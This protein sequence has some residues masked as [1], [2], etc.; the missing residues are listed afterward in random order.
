[1][2]EHLDDPEAALGTLARMARPW[3]L[4]SVPREPAWRAMNMARLKYLG[5]LGNTPGHLG[6]WSKRGFIRFLEREVEVVEVATPL[7]WTM[8]LCRSE[9]LPVNA[10]RRLVASLRRRPGVAAI[11]ALGIAWGLTMHAMGWAQ[12]AFFAQ[13]RALADGGAEIDRWHWESGDKAWID[14]HFYSVKAPGVPALSAPLYL[15]ID[16]EPGRDLTAA[17]VD[18]QRTTEHRRWWP[19][20]TPPYASQG[21]VRERAFDVADG[22]EQNAPRVWALTL[23]ISVIPAVF[24][25][26]GV[27]W[28]GDRLEPGYGTAAAVTLGV[29]TIV[30]SFAAEY[31][32]HVISAT[33][34]FSAFLLLMREREG[35]PSLRTVAAAGLLAG[36]AVSFEYQTGLVGAV[37]FFYALA[38]SGARLPRA[39]SYVAGAVAGAIPVF[40]YNWF[41]LGTPFEFAY[42]SAVSVIGTTGHAELGLNSDGFFGITVPSPDKAI[43]LFFSQRGLL[44]L[45]PILVMAVVGTVLMRRRHRAEANVILAVGAVYLLYNFGYWQPLGGGT[46]GPRFLMPALP[47][48]AIGL[49]TAYRRLPAVTLGLAIASAVCMVTAASTYTLIGEQG[50]GTWVEWLQDGK[51]ENTL[52]TAFGVS[53]AWLAMAPVLAAVVAA[54]VL[55]ARATPATRLGDLRWALGALVLWVGVSITGPSLAKE[56]GHPFT[57]DEID[58]PLSGDPLAIDLVTTAAAIAALV[59]GGL[60]LRERRAQDR[61]ASAGPAAS[62][63]AARGPGLGGAGRVRAPCG[64]RA[65]HVDQQRPAPLDLDGEP[66]QPGCRRV[67]GRKRRGASQVRV[68]HDRPGPVLA[69]LRER[70]TARERVHLLEQVLHPI[71]LGARPPVDDLGELVGGPEQV[72]AVLVRHVRRQV[73]LGLR[74]VRDTRRR[75]RNGGLGLAVG[76]VE[77]EP[78]ALDQDGQHQHARDRRWDQPPPRAGSAASFGSIPPRSVR[79]ATGRRPPRA[80]PAPARRT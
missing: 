54:G 7:P 69:D 24:L 8:A 44:T 21:Y 78:A 63:G 20:P 28:V 61:T 11:L 73:Q 57:P 39:A 19:T 76:W 23:F 40:I 53:N 17:A 16:T 30:M 31:F 37:L 38:R 56:W 33:L 48:L 2:L 34:G 72:G 5:D 22:N 80:G 13:T 36:L 45:T 66:G 9:G 29:A 47:F 35:P 27:R 60:W 59:L 55:A 52:L 4:V 3:L 6:H 58:V 12:N 46:P 41:A 77:R 75:S 10:L 43:E 49:A 65:Q 14:G 26:F 1:M 79:A 42:G 62:A 18:N 15:L 50:T 71:G 64:L 32:S 74:H 67:V 70:T 68:D 51:L 25:L